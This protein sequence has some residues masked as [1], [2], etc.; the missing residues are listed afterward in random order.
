MR[1]VFCH[2]VRRTQNT[3]PSTPSGSN[4]G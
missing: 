3:S 2:V 1:R 4:C